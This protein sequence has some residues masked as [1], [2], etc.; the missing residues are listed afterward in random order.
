MDAR[1]VPLSIIASGANVHDV[2]LLSATLDALVLQPTIP[3][4]VARPHLCADAGYRG[5]PAQKQIQ[6]RHY[7]PHVKARRQEIEEKKQN[8]QNKPRR[9][10]V[11]RT[12]SWFNR[13]RKILVS[14]E[15]SEESFLGL[16]SLAAAMICWKRAASING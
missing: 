15:K 9:W 4:S 6:E 13:F 11:E 14:F 2:K 8:S 10:V 16:L 1:G 12:H 7:Q 5:A 3:A